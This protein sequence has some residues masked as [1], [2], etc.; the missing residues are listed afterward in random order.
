MPGLYF[1]DRMLKY[2]LVFS[3]VEIYKSKLVIGGKYSDTLRLRH[4]LFSL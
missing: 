4:V 1:I 2:F 3:L